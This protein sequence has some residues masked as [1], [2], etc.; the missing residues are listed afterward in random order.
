MTEQQKEKALYFMTPE[1]SGSERADVWLEMAS[2][3]VDEGYFGSSYPLALCYMASH[4]GTLETRGG[5][6]EVGSVSSKSE[7]SISISYSPA[8]SGTDDDLLQTTYGRMFLKLRDNCRPGPALT[9]FFG[10]GG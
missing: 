9:G 3:Q 8:G 2:L 10:F 7:G 6:D 5:G 1:L 4:I